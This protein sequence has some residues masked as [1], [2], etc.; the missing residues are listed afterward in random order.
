MP[1]PPLARHH[2]KRLMDVWRSA[3]WPCQDGVEIDLLAAG[4]LERQTSPEGH[5]LL[6]VTDAGI[7]WLAD[8]RRAGQRRI[9]LHDRMALAFARQQLLPAG[10]VVWRELSLRAELLPEGGGALVSDAAPEAPAP[11]PVLASLWDESEPTLPQRRAA[12]V[13]RVARPDLFSVR[14]T[15]VPGYLHPLV[16]EI[17]ASRADLLSDLRHAAKR[18]AYQWLCEGCHYVFPAGIAEADELPP[19]FGV[20]MMHG[21]PDEDGMGA[22]FELARPARHARC[23]LPFDVWM[24][25][26]KATPLGAGGEPAQARLG[27]A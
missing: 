17:K 10:R 2:R 6:R 14:N 3:G 15:S 26:C 4:M 21:T 1:P 7:A 8:E 25:L 27:P 16:H 11:P 19:E 13:W 9:S 23:T 20:W 18:R 24:A 22:R 12:R 5:T